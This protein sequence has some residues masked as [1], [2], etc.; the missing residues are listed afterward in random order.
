MPRDTPPVPEIT[1]Q[2]G[3]ESVRVTGRAAEI[4]GLLVLHAERVNT[5]SVGRLVANFAHGKTNIE[6]TES[7]PALRLDR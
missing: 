6:L 3:G 4:I 2:A 5:I 1:V 7:L